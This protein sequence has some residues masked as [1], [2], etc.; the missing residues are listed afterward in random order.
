M[1]NF[2]TQIF[3]QLYT[4]ALG[5]RLNLSG[6]TISSSIRYNQ[7]ITKSNP[8]F[9]A[10]THTHVYLDEGESCYGLTLISIHEHQCVG[11]FHLLLTVLGDMI[12]PLV[13]NQAIIVSR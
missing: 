5:P 1:S 3:Y 10:C 4:S 7:S 8:W 13:I 2:E 12:F 9:C 6:I 11:C